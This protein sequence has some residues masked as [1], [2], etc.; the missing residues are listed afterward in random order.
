MSF[1]LALLCLASAFFV[2]YLAPQTGSL[3][4]CM[5]KEHKSNRAFDKVRD[6]TMPWLFMFL[7][8]FSGDLVYRPKVTALIYGAVITALVVFIGLFSP[9]FAVVTGIAALVLVILGFS[10]SFGLLNRIS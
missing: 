6:T 8:I 5:L 10:S 3:L 7:E 4:G 2:L 9:S 1:I